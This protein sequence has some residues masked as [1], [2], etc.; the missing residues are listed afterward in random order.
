MNETARPYPRIL[1]ITSC[2]GEKRQK[3]INQLIQSDFYETEQLKSREEELADFA[4]PASQLYT[5]SQHLQVMKGVNHLR[6]ALGSEVIDL[7]ILSAGYG[8]IPEDQII[9]P[10]EVSFNTMT[11]QE[12]DEWSRFLDIH[13]SLE[14]AIH[15]Y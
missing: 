11:G 7:M 2:T 15:N 12:I 9:V 6:D 13:R 1:V 8:L 3:P 4:T 10:Y 5:G 14:Q